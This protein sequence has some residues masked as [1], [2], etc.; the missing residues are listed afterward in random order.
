M[1]A[2]KHAAVAFIGLVGLAMAVIAASVLV[3][4]RFLLRLARATAIAFVV[5]GVVYLAGAV[6]TELFGGRYFE[7]HGRDLTYA[8]LGT[9]EETLEVTG[10]ILFITALLEYRRSMDGHA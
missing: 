8:A 1:I 3:F 2:T 10:V 9:L 5:A 4:R 6:G 7:Q